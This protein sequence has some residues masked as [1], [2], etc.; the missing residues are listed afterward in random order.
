MN[1]KHLLAMTLVAGIA[2]TGCSSKND[3]A[4]VA[5]ETELTT[6]EEKVETGFTGEA[7]SRTPVGA[8]SEEVIVTTITY[9]NGTPKNVMID[10]NTPKGSKRELVVTGQYDMKNDG[11]TW[12]EQVDALQAFIVEN[13]FDL[14]KVTLTDEAGHTDAV[15]GVSIAIGSY[16]PIIESLLT[17]V[18]DGTY[19]APTFN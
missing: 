4:P 17:S 10:I 15:T 14:T 3:Q 9:E 13:N 16:L 2:L 8:E 18:E 5:P 6:P 11:L 1:F 19:V 7:V 12:S